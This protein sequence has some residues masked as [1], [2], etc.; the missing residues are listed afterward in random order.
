MDKVKLIRAI[1]NLQNKRIAVIGDVAL[2]KYVYGRVE[3]V[4]PENPGA[5]L[6]KIERKEFRLGCAANVA[7]NLAVLGADITLCCTIGNDYYGKLFE[8]L[9][10]RNKIRL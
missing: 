2:D 8:D 6:L 3:R 10:K 1:K 5:P 9:C 7:K 4:N